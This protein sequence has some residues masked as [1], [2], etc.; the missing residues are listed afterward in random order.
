MNKTKILYVDDESINL[1]LFEANLEKKYHVFTASDGLSGLNIIN[2]EGDIKVV[3]SDMKMP[4][5]NGLEFIQKARKVS[6]H[7][8]YYILTG[9]E[10]SDEIQQ[11]INIGIIRRYFKKPF[12]M[13]EISSEIETVINGFS[14]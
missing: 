7:I 8:C 2:S 14:K 10:I 9:F 6:P 4:V 12:N 5:M 1:M 3:L 13:N 11:A